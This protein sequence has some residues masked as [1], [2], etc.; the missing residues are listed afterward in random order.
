MF[1][2]THTALLLLNAAVFFSS[3]QVNLQGC[4]SERKLER[5]L[6]LQAHYVV[7]FSEKHSLFNNDNPCQTH[8]LNLGERHGGYF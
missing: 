6:I 2:V 5:L 8:K 1:F 7:F 4:F 3:V